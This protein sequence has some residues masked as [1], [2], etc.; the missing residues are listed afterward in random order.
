MDVE[1]NRTDDALPNQRRRTFFKAAFGASMLQTSI[2]S[3]GSKKN[4]IS[5]V[6]GNNATIAAPHDFELDAV[7]GN[8]RVVRGHSWSTLPLHFAVPSTGLDTSVPMQVSAI[9]VR[10]QADSGAKIVGLALH[11]CETTVARIDHLD[12]RL[13][14]WGDVR[15]PLNPPRNVVRSIGV[16]LDCEFADVERQISISAVG[17]EFQLVA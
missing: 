14:E 10:L 12:L 7:H 8:T 16:T 17:C 4:P 11:D 9:W 13:Q 5:W 3:A 15:I 6:H 1:K 2:A